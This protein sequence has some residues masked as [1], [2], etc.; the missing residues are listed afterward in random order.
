MSE[1]TEVPEP[2]T[3]LSPQ[4]ATRLREKKEAAR[5]AVLL[6]SPDPL[7]R[8]MA[9]LHQPAPLHEF[10]LRCLGCDPGPPNHANWPCR[11]WEL[12]DKTAAANA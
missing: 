9:E 10:W 7:T 5:H 2:G 11:T 8:A 6:I 1:S 3:E 12:L 4:A